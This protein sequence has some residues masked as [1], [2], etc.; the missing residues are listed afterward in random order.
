MN[1][2]RELRKG[3]KLT[4]IEL[5]Q[6]LNISQGTLSGYESGRF[7]PDLDTM[8]KMADFFGVTIDYLFCRSDE[9]VSAPIVPD[10]DEDTLAIREQ[11]RRRPGMRTLFD[12]ARGAS[13]DDL[14]RAVRIIEALKGDR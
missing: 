14:L 11:L 1:R 4:Q 9:E 8:S 13:D 6:K 2:I 12:A 10:D 5:S 3:R 7:E